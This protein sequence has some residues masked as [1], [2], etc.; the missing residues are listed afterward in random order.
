MNHFHRIKRIEQRLGIIM[1]DKENIEEI[2][3]FFLT[4]D[5]NLLPEKPTLKE[6]YL[7]ALKVQGRDIQKCKGLFF[8][9]DALKKK[10]KIQNENE[11]FSYLKDKTYPDRD[12]VYLYDNDKLDDSYRVLKKLGIFVLAEIRVVNTGSKD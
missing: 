7:A 3:E 6:V 9:I 11:F 4:G 10:G 8:V 2:Y 5:E 12:M 1:P